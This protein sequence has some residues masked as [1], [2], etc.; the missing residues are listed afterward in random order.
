MKKMS[1][2]KVVMFKCK[3]KKNG[4][5]ELKGDEASTWATGRSET[6]QPAGHNG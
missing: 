1:N 6:V 3:K 5:A 2:G 4:I